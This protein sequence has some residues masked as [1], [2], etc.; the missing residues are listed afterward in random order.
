VCRLGGGA[1][2]RAVR[3][4]RQ[5]G[6][7]GGSRERGHGAR[8]ILVGGQVAVEQEAD[9]RGPHPRGERR[10]LGGGRAG[11][12][13]PAQPVTRISAR[14][15]TRSAAT[16]ARVWHSTMSARPSTASATA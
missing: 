2:A 9:R 3:G 5:A 16:S 7:D 11:G 13:S 8:R 6:A 4:D 12:S 14:V 1:G 10:D 15:R